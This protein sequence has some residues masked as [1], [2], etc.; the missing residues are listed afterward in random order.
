MPHPQT[1]SCCVLLLVEDDENDAYFV[2]ETNPRADSVRM[3]H[4][5]DGEEA[6]RYLS[7]QGD[8]ADLDKY[9]TP[10]AVLTDFK[11]P[12]CNGI[13][14]VRWIRNRPEFSSMPCLILSSSTIASDIDAARDAGAATFITK[15]VN[16]RGYS[17]VWDVL[18]KFC[19]DKDCTWRG[20]VFA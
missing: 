8:Y 10:D 2:M 5:R 14:L 4:V 3:I 20:A 6:K 11:M 1:V 19:Q 7:R 18:L 17:K 12:F 16:L 13:E 15:P 9:P